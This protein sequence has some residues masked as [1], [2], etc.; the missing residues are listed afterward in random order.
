VVQALQ[1]NMALL[2]QTR[3]IAKPFAM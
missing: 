1:S 3:P 2:P